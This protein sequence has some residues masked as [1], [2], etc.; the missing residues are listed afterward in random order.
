MKKPLIG[1]TAAHLIQ[2]GIDGY[3]TNS[4]Y[5]DSVLR[6]GG[7]PVLLVP[8]EDKETIQTLAHELDGM[9]L[10][11]GEDTAPCFYG[12]EAT[13]QITCTD[14][15][16]DLFEITLIHEMNAQKKPML[17]ICRGHQLLNIAFG[18]NVY[19]DIAAQYPKAICH[20][21]RTAVKSEPFHKVKLTPGSA[22]AK[23]VGAT[24]LDVNTYHHQAINRVA[25]EF[26]VTGNS[27]DGMI[28]A[29]ESADGTMIGVQWH[30]ECMSLRFHCFQL[31]FD[32]FVALCPKTN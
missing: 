22:V 20:C 7:I 23:L 32:G 27:S 15:L 17:G 9:I 5:V 19:Q 21:Q 26:V 29:I 2:N 13:P 1:I 14:R 6:A 31:M 28:E 25:D 30:P 4:G 12:E 16:L 24:E 10:P 3:K 11:G 8:T 18:G